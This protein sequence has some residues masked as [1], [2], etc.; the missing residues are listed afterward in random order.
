MGVSGSVRRLKSR[1]WKTSSLI[2][3]LKRL[4]EILKSAPERGATVNPPSPRPELFAEWCA[5]LARD[6]VQYR[7]LRTSIEQR[8]DL[9]AKRLHVIGLAVR[10]ECRLVLVN[11]VVGEL[12]R[13]FG[14]LVQDIGER[15]GLGRF[16][17]RDHFF[18]GAF[19]R[20]FAAGFHF[21]FRDYCNRHRGLL[22]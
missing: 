16:H 6:F 18:C 15:A 7:D 14:V 12:G 2:T 1:E 5:L 9:S 20:G 17:R 8:A 19:E 22:A 4:L 21:K 3:K 13:G 10:I 11:L